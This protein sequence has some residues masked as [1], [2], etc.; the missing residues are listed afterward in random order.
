MSRAIGRHVGT[1]DHFQNHAS[2]A[3]KALANST[4]GFTDSL[5]RQSGGR[6]DGSTSSI[7]RWRHHHHL[8]DGH[9]TRRMNGRIARIGHTRGH[10]IDENG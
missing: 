8:I 1:F 10:A 4:T 5:Q 9:H 6:G 3:V 2:G 7:E